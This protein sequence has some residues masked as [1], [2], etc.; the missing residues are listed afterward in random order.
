MRDEKDGRKKQ[1]RSNLHVPNNKAKQHS[2]PKA[3]TF[4]KKIAASGG[5]Q[6]HDTPHSRQSALP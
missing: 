6:T 4:P 5:I 1:A 2:V 3:V